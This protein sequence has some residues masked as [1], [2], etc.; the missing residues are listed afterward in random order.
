MAQRNPVLALWAS[1]SAMGLRSGTLTGENSAASA[2]NSSSAGQTNE[3]TV[4]E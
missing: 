4:E 3:S 2:M 1:S